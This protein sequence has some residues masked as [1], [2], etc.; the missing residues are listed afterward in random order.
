MRSVDSL[1]EMLCQKEG[2]D[3]TLHIPTKAVLGKGFLV[4]KINFFHMIRYLAN[5]LPEL[6]EE[7]I[8]INTIISENEEFTGMIG[9]TKDETLKV[10][11]ALD[12]PK[13]I[14]GEMVNSPIQRLE[15]EHTINNK[16]YNY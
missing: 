13:E 8:E 4:A 1:I 12:F 6:R 10:L 5:P 7:S 11:K 2:F 9:F 3:K 14:I 16:K 15:F